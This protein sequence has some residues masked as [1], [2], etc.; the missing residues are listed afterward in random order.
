MFKCPN[1]DFEV[2]DMKAKECKFKCKARGNFQNPAD[3]R[4]YYYCSGVNAQPIS[5]EC[6]EDW[7]FDGIG[8]NIDADKCLY[9][10]TTT[11]TPPPELS[12]LKLEDPIINKLIDDL[13][14]NLI[15]KICE[16]DSGICDPQ[17]PPNDLN[18]VVDGYR[19]LTDGDVVKYIVRLVFIYFTFGN[20]VYACHH[21]IYFY[22]LTI[23]ISSQ[24]AT[25]HVKIKS[26][27]MENKVLSV[28][29]P[30]TPIADIT[31]FD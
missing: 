30:G 29:K 3:C 22:S 2:F 26:D 10:P 11:T 4:L 23:T 18:M 12:A 25:L 17:S 21:K 28:E 8:C 19:T 15:P 9:K 16:Y 13:K 20:L 5:G 31:E 27:P 24:S 6:P 14:S 1:E 7:V